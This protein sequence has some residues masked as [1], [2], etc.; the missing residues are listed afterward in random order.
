[1]TTSN[2]TQNVPKGWPCCESEQIRVMLLGAFHM[3]N[4]GLDEVNVDADDVL[5][6]HRQAELRELV[7]DL[8]EWEPHRVAVERPYDRNEEI[9]NR[10]R[11]YQSGE[12]EYGLEEKFPAPHPRRNDSNSEC[13]SEVVQVGF[14]LADHLGHDYVSAIDEHPD[15]SRYDP[16]P[17]KDREIDATRKSSVTVQDRETAKNEVDERLA[18]STIP[19]YLAWANGKRNLRDNHDDMFDKG[20]R[21]VD[22]PFGSPNALAYWYDRNI[23][24]VHHL[25]RTTNPDDDRVLLLI[26]SGH[27]RV[28]RHLLEEAPMFCPV[29]PLPY[30]PK[31]V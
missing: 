4:P 6:D 25:W 20:I 31:D 16:D 22:E 3:D 12:R 18:S 19:E 2:N 21:T 17:F 10:Y 24:I 15:E 13:R 5:S 29:S 7:N 27:V 26:G 9:N 14:R 28:L 11:E 1:M 30:L 23:R 8:A